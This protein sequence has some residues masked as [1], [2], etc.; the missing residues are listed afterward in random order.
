MPDPKA[1]GLFRGVDPA[2]RIQ[3]P[4]S[5]SESDAGRQDTEAVLYRT[6]EIDGTRVREILRRARDFANQEPE[7]YRLGKDLI[8]KEKVVRV[9]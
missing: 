8:V 2:S 3:S 7:R 1:C 5:Q 6:P 9:L 4:S